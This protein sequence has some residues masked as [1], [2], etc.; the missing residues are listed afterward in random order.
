MGRRLSIA[1]TP[2]AGVCAVA[3]ARSEDARGFFSRIFCAD[4]LAEVLQ[5]RAIVQANQTLTRSVGSVRG[6]HYQRPPH[7]EMKLIRCLRGRVFDVAVDLRAGSPTFGRWHAIELSA[8]GGEMIIIPE[9]CAH[10]F[11]V[12]EP[13]TE[14]LYLH[15]RA[16]APDA[17]AGVHCEDPRLAIAWPLPVQ[18]LSDRDRAL[19]RLSSDFQGI[20]P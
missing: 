8:D 19:P 14:L 13:D 7:A 9:G 12:L 5:G 20:R 4:E 1:A 11:Q 6:L 15:T 10:G 3:T 2:L 18:R 16:Y 17:E